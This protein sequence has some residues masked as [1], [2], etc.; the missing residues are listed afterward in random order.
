MTFFGEKRWADDVHPHES[1]K[2]MT[3]PLIVL[4]ALSVLGGLLI[5]GDWIV[6]WLDPVVGGPPPED[7]VIPA[8]LFSLIIVATV[9]VGVAVAWFTIG[10]HPVP[11]VA[12]T[13]VSPFTRAARAD[14]YGDAINDTLVVRPTMATVDGLLAFDRGVVDGAV[15][16]QAAATGGFAQVF[17]RWQNGF[18]RAYALSLL[19]GAVLVVLALMVVNVA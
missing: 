13:E 17:R 6:N 9:A 19:A 7:P 3:V 11:R 12:P 2:V 5:A 8:T 14:I 15:M 16:G 4:A 1:P 10:R 18:V